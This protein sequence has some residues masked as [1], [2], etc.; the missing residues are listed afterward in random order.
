[1]RVEREVRGYLAL[2]SELV[3]IGRQQQLDRG[4]VKADAMVQPLYAV[5]RI[6]A[7]DGQHSSQNL[8]FRDAGRIS[9]KQRLDVERLRRLDYVIDAVARNIHPRQLIH[10]LIDLCDDDALLEGG[11]FDD[12]GRVLRVRTHIKIAV[13][14]GAPGHGQRDVWR[15]VDEV[16]TE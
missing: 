11:R 3:G 2:E 13:A 5:F 16:P 14:V 8:R 10:H 15:K 1:M 6:D 12:D 4:R 7:L 9:S